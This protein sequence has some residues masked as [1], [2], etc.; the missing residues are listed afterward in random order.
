[1][2][3]AVARE[4]FRVLHRVHEYINIIKGSIV[5][6]REHDW[7]ISYNNVLAL[8]SSL[9]VYIRLGMRSVWLHL[10]L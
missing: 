5:D 9:F 8:L 10:R 1:M 3:S 4:T 2:R 6:S 7:S